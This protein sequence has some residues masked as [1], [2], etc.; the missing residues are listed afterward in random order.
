MVQSDPKKL[1]AL[2]RRL[3]QRHKIEA[4]DPLD[5]VTRLTMSFLQWETSRRRAEQAF[6]DLMGTLVD[7]NE[8]RV[9]FEPE[10]LESIGKDYPLSE[11]RLMRLRSALNEIYVREHDVRMHSIENKNKK[12]QR[13]YLETLPG[14]VPY[15]TAQVMLLSFGSHAIPVDHRLVQLLAHEKVVDESTSVL[16]VEAFLT[17][18][19]KASDAISVH[20]TLQAWADSSRRTTTVSPA[21]LCVAVDRP[22][23]QKK[24]TKRSAGRTSTP[25]K[26]RNR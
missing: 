9:T 7:I 4:P 10:L 6:D 8:L 12:E 16:E 26:S 25:K 13:A 19:I 17:R 21:I 23:Q 18:Q 24:P 22:V 20:Q 2:V 15:V 11:E 3:R 1:A 14:I 5:P